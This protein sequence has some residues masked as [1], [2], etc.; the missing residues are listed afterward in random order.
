MEVREWWTF[1]KQSD[2]A[3]VLIRLGLD[4]ALAGIP[5]AF[6]PEDVQDILIRRVRIDPDLLAPDW[7]R[8]SPHPKIE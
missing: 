4:P 7:K 3:A 5:S 1:A 8:T 6:L 2:Q